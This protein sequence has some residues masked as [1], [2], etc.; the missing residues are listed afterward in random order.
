L[1]LAGQPLVG[2]TVHEIAEAAQSSQALLTPLASLLGEPDFGPVTRAV[3][4]SGEGALFG[5]GLALGLTRRASA[6]SH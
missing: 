1:T 5:A 4:G 6:T 2:G 3:I